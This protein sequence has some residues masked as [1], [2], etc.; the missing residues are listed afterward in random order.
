MAAC[1]GTFT[2]YGNPVQLYMAAT[3][4]FDTTRLCGFVIEND[5]YVPKEFPFN[6]ISDF[7]MEA[8]DATH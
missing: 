7:G 2:A 3:N 6:E 8:S 4:R 5:E 1:I